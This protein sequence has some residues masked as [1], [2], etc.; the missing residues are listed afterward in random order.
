M[1]KKV[2]RMDSNHSR[3]KNSLNS[4][5]RMELMFQ[6]KLKNEIDH[7]LSR[8]SPGHFRKTLFLSPIQPTFF[9]S[10]IQTW[11]ENDYAALDDA[12]KCLAG[13][14]MPPRYQRAYI[15]R[16]RGHA[17][18]SDIAIQIAWILE[19]APHEVHGLAAAADRDQAG[20]VWNAMRKLSRINPWACR[21]L[22][23]RQNRVVNRNSGSQ[24]EIIS[25]DVQS[26]WGALP[27]FVICDE[28]CHWEKPDLWHS[29]I[30]SAA[31]RST[32]LLVVLTNAGVGRDW[33]WDVRE[34][35]RTSDDW[36]F[37][38]LNGPQAPWI[39][40]KQLNEQ[41]EILP[42]PV[43][44]R[45]WEN[46]WQH[47]DGQFVTLDEVEACR[48][49]GL[50][51]Q[52]SGQ[53]GIQ[54]FAAV[55]YAEKHDYTV[56]VVLHRE[57]DTIIV[58][59]MDVTVPL[60]G[61][62]VRV[63]WVEDWIQRTATQFANVT[64]VVDEYQL[65]GTIQKLESQFQINRFPFAA[66]RGNHAMAMALRQLIVHARLRWYPGC[67]ELGT[68]N[69]RDDLETELASL[70]LHQSAT[71][72][73]R[74]IHPPGRKHHDDRAFA[75]GAACLTAL[76]SEAATQWMEVVHANN[77]GEIAWDDLTGERF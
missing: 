58:D 15:E 11:Q 2:N 62:P 31:K 39:H 57:K 46:I 64:F 50:T 13:F 75:L 8:T 43:Y 14:S 4:Q 18:T 6:L 71:G 44:E 30:S 73:C 59:R 22:E 66:G 7:R 77:P 1:Q 9:R 32:C 34:A 5:E 60:P 10:L 51:I 16:P 27:D 72:H 63:S 26:S 70:L 19:H 37:S 61:K 36:Y 17:K 74:F 52:D 49:D 12:W 21:S 29:L 24:L 38:S 68:G 45:L 23:F 41:K 69:G 76:Q 40:Q 33:H 3:T 53:A 54:Y 20:L 35:A 42:R 47:S 25:S 67:G 48:S 55:D 28:L 56:G 65:L